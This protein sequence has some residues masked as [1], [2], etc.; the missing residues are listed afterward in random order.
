MSFSLSNKTWLKNRCLGF[1]LPVRSTVS[2]KTIA[3]G[4]K[5]KIRIVIFY[6]RLWKRIY[7]KK[8][9]TGFNKTRLFNKFEFSFFKCKK[10]ETR[11]II[12][13]KQRRKI[14]QID[15][16]FFL[17]ADNRN[18]EILRKETKRKMPCSAVTLSIATISAIIAI[19]LLGIAFSTDNWL[20]YEV[21]RSNIQVCIH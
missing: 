11:I 12:Q 15:Q 14:K 3:I 10:Y 7:K 16:Y 18:F 4:V 9:K 20:H 2:S 6:C 8:S 1:V 21:K 13:K 5:T 19:A 17:K